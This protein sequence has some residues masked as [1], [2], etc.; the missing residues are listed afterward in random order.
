[1]SEIWSN[2][3]LVGLILAIPSTILGLLAYR[4][5]RAVD[6]VTERTQ[7]ATTQS[8]SINQVISGLETLVEN[9][10]DDNKWLRERA[11]RLQ[12]NVQGLE[13]EVG[14]LKKDFRQKV[15]ELEA[16]IAILKKALAKDIDDNPR[17]S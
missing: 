12:Q 13:T 14:T 5:S 9:L 11:E 3:L 4:R 8:G 10:Q 17:L 1:M 15:Q 16:E 7:E 6:K 2:P